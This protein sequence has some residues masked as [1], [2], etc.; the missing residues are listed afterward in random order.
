MSSIKIGLDA[1]GLQD[2]HHLKCALINCE[3]PLKAI[4]D[5]QEENSILLPTL[6][7]ALP[8]LDLHSVKRL[9]FHQS[10]AD[11]LK[12]KLTKR[13]EELS[14]SKTQADLSKLQDL[15][16]KSFPVIK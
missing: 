2:S 3:D 13:I 8:L 16:D 11:E 9:D 10:V 14:D 6:K 7:P 5:F 15:L 4:S 12:D 1:L